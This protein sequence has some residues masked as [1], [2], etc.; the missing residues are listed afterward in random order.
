M[1]KFLV[2]EFFE[3]LIRNIRKLRCTR[4]IKERLN[5]EYSAISENGF[6][7]ID[8]FLSRDEC[9]A[10]IKE[11]DSLINKSDINLWVDSKNSDHRLYFIDTINEKFA[12]FLKNEYFL[13][14]LKVYTGI[15]SPVGM[16]LAGRVDAVDGNVGSGGGWHRDSPIQHQ[17]KAICYLSDVD[18]SNGP[19]QYIPKSHKKINI[20]N[21]CF[22]KVFR[23]GQYRFSESDIKKY[24]D[25]TGQEAV[26][27]T[28][29]AGKLMFVDTKGIHRGKPIETGSRYVLF[30]YFW[31]KKIPNH[32]NKYKQV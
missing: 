12:E 3:S 32:F 9:S 8:G 31:N 4:K 27:M 18:E 26:N 23:P 29:E 24:C 20:I 21:M 19:F 1:I 13:N 2:K 28:G 22:K 11:I 6:H 10:L 17:T 30:C 25:E 15:D 7:S 14:V 16:L 5:K